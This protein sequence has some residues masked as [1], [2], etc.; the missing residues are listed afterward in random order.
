MI[1][2]YFKI[3]W[4]NLFRNKGFS[5]TNLLGLTIGITCTILIFL[6]VQDELAY[7]KFHAN[8]KSIYKVMATRDFNNQVFTDENMVLPLASTLQDKLPQIKNAV[9]TTHRQSH[10]LSH[11]DNKLK[12]SGYTVSDRF[13]DMFS[14]KF[15]RG[16]SSSAIADPS[17]IVLTKST[18]KAFFANDDPINKVVRIDDDRDAKVTAVVEDP[19]GN[20]TFQFEY[21]TPFNV[22]SDNYKRAFADWQNSSWTVFVQVNPGTNMQALEKNINDI[23]KQ[24][25]ATDKKISTYFTFP[26]NK[27]RLYSDFKN[28]KN[29][30]GMIEY[31]TLFTIIAIIILLIACVNFMNLST[32]RSEKRAKE[33]GV[34]KTLGSGKKQLILQFFFESMILAFV[35][36]ILSIAAVYLLLPSF[37][38]LVDKHLSVPIG[39]PIFW[40]GALS[41]IMCTGI[42]AG[43]YPALYLS[44]FNPI[45][46][47][48]GTFLAGKTAAIPRRILV[49][50]QFA[51]S[52]LLISATIIIYEQ[53]QHVKNRDIGY[54]PNNLITIPATP[55]TQKNFAVI[56]QELLQTGMVSAVTRT[57]SPIT[58]IWWKSPAPDWEG[59]PA[60]LN[61]IFSGMN[62]DV[63]FTKTMGIKMLQGKD[64]S[65]TPSDSSAMLLNKAAIEAMGLKNPVGMQMRYG[66]TY[67]VIGVTDNVIQESP[68]KPVDPM[69]VYFGPDGANSI[70][71]RLNRSIQPR[72]ALA[73]IE[74]IFK[75]YNPAYPFEYQF[76]DQEFGKK[77]L[78]E[79]LI[80][81]I[82]NIFAGLAIFICCIGLAG[83]ASFTIEK[84][85][86]EIGIRKVL[87]AT[88]QQLLLLISKEFLR[89]VLI[90]FLIA[91][92]ITWWF[93]NNWLDK[94]TYHIRISI[95]L[96]AA[97]GIVIML[98]TLVVVSLNT[99][100]A[101][102]ANPV[103]SLR[104]E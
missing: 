85:I 100:R 79:E 39:Q 12:K 8:Y 49:V 99:M 44:S 95:W 61:M 59:K 70:T 71:L 6:W 48:K 27:W 62:T 34:R 75:K 101:A 65:G 43:S 35:A 16:G 22:S 19:P 31:V 45:K 32:A 24:R 4:R 98:L 54:D 40:L 47:L 77:F 94:Y 13:F 83:L 7:D 38:T 102:V 20:S 33:V 60:D 15:I 53:I 80:S 76:V 91:V 66:K 82:T 93:M 97:V 1:R 67:T 46:V 86:R 25:D 10:V 72:R 9:V 2:N 41:I 11:G 28:G 88:V 26:M 84:R 5:L 50:A 74:N 73:S 37:N 52:I 104:T 14:W 42:V 63:D 18:A 21:L 3:A 78:T 51:T 81:K 89:L 96:F 17:S 87:G 29:T 23:K 90:A 64:F 56:K 92:P 103:K 36:F 69:M 30:G 58:D 57:F 55:D 68:F